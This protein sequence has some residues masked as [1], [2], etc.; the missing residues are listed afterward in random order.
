[1]LFLDAVI[2][3]VTG[4][5]F[6][7]NALSKRIKRECKSTSPPSDDGKHQGR[8]PIN[9]WLINLNRVINVQL[10]FRDKF[11]RQLCF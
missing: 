2:L 3:R 8:V 6:D 7:A 1:M 11:P 9:D 10:S 5:L 4:S